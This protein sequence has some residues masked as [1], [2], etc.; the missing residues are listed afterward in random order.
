M[1]EWFKASAS[2]SGKGSV[3]SHT[4]FHLVW[5]RLCP[6]IVFNMKLVFYPQANQSDYVI[7]GVKLPNS[8]DFQGKLLFTCLCV[9][10]LQ[11]DG[12]W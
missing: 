3:S 5:V 12:L 8:E 2:A 1:V 11:G 4:G 10:G 7:C 9:S 6:I